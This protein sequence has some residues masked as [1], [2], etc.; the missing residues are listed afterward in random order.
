MNGRTLFTRLI[1]ALFL[2]LIFL[3]PAQAI[4]GVGNLSLLSG[5]AAGGIA[6]SLAL[7]ELGAEIV[8]ARALG[9]L[10]R[11]ADDVA[12]GATKNNALEGVPVETFQ[13]SIHRRMLQ[14]D[15]EAF[16]Y[17]GGASDPKGRFLTT[18]Q[19]IR[20]INSSEDAQRVLQLPAEATAE[21]L[22][23]FTI[24]KGTEIFAGRVRG[25]PAG[26][27]Q[28]FIKDPGVLR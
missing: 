8:A 22:N 3:A 26:A 25:G 27:S 18:R 28:V 5:A 20:Q 23:S 1:P 12:R 16:R 13:G 19:T 24:P 4:G 9:A 17:S 15:V 2:G 11:V 6:A 14:N 7:P 21:K 10:G